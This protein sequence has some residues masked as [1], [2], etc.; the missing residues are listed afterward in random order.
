MSDDVIKATGKVADLTKVAENNYAGVSLWADAAQTKYRSLKDYLG[1]IAKIFDKIDAGSQTKLLE[2]LFG[3]RGAS[4]GSSIL[5]NFDQI[6]KAIEEMENAAGAADAEMEIIRSSWEYKLNNFKQT[7]VGIFQEL[8]DRGA[9]GDLIDALTKISELLSKIVGNK[10][11]LGSLAS[12]ITGIVASV[13]GL[14]TVTFLKDLKQII[15]GN[16]LNNTGNFLSGLFGSKQFS[17][18]DTSKMISTYSGLLSGDSEQINIATQALTELSDAERSVM[19]AAQKGKMSIEEFSN[20]LSTM[21]KGANIAKAAFNALATAGITLVAIAIVDW[22]TKGANALANLSKNTSEAAKAIRDSFQSAKDTADANLKTFDELAPRLEKLRKGVDD[23][24]NNLSLTDEEYAEFQSI[25]QTIADM[26]PDLIQGYND[27]NG[28]IV[29]LKDSVTELRKEYEKAQAAAYSLMITG[30]DE[31]GKSK[32]NTLIQDYKNT[33]ENPDW[34]GLIGL[35]GGGSYYR[36]LSPDD[37]YELLKNLRDDYNGTIENYQYIIAKFQWENPEYTAEDIT[38]FLAQNFED[39]KDLESVQKTAN[40][41]VKAYETTKKENLKNF[42][43]TVLTAILKQEGSDFYNLSEEA[44]SAISYVINN[45]DEELAYDL[46]KR[47]SGAIYTWVQDQINAI[48]GLSDS[49]LDRYSSINVE[50]P[51]EDILDLINEI[52]ALPGFDS[53][54]PLIIHL[55]EIIDNKQDLQDRVTNKLLGVNN[56]YDRKREDIYRS[57]DYQE[58]LTGLDKKQI[59]LVLNAAFGPKSFSKE[60]LDKYLEEL[61][62]VANEKTIEIRTVIDAVDTF[63]QTK[64]ALSS[65][66]DLYEE[67]VTNGKFASPDTLN[68]VEAAFGGIA[69]ESPIVAQALTNFENVMLEF[70]G[71]ANKA[72]E[73]IN[74]LV[75]AYIDQSDILKDL[76]EENKEWKIATLE[77]MGITN[78]QEVVESRLT[79]TSKASVQ[80]LSKLRDELVKFNEVKKNE[81]NNPLYDEK[82]FKLNSEE[83]IQALSDLKE[84][85]KE[86]LTVYDSEGEEYYRQLE[87]SDSFVKKHLADIQAM[88]E[89]DK[90]ALERVKQA[91]SKEQLGDSILELHPELSTQ[92]VE[93]QVNT[94]ADYFQNIPDME[95]GTSLDTGAFIDGLNTLLASGKYTAEQVAE[96]MKSMGY[97]VQINQAKGKVIVPNANGSHVSSTYGPNGPQLQRWDMQEMEMSFPS[98][99]IITK[100]G[101][102]G[103]GVQAEA[104]NYKPPKEESSSG[105]GG[106]KDET[107]KLTEQMDVL[108]WLYDNDVIDYKHYLD[109]KKVL[110]DRALAQG[111]I[112]EKRYFEE[113]HTWLRETLD[114]YNS[115]ISYATKL[116]DKEI[117]RLEKE[118]DER[119]KQIEN[120][121]KAAIE[122]VDS[123]LDALDKRIKKKNEE[124]EL[125]EKEH[126]QRKANMDMARAEYNLMRS[127]YQKSN[128]VK[129]CQAL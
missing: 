93:E 41:L 52:L 77:A 101:A 38:Q 33:F 71:D 108:K 3:K 17:Q 68:S 110:L 127:L 103:G 34:G 29:D 26:S 98:V 57:N 113:I 66:S 20:S 63:D 8:A 32:I 7:W 83:Y 79:A 102:Y 86:A 88:A 100:K 28:A 56:G 37:A 107:D 118:R 49:I 21:N 123:E 45:I 73:A 55:Q 104:A 13:K 11:A 27:Q 51:L 14:D 15:S 65:L 48:E 87:L 109:Q 78:A 82:G 75:S 16:N 6:E 19:S 85:V 80:A 111:L 91:A 125:M 39:L 99:K 95:I 4:V 129:L 120:E 23:L 43:D 116:L 24:G 122:A 70:P 44:Q 46:A 40:T 96:F 62:K 54:N 36:N 84:K 74:R 81:D 50:T 114:L 42:K 64:Q 124:I 72:Q 59:D 92:E 67:T 128:L 30:R 60:D 1:D 22:A 106:S 89:G 126:D 53:D 2:S 69:E 94:L 112:D 31:K 9:I 105:G 10:F 5:K 97:D 25:S 61:Q 12:V 119:L 47:G 18:F 76:T 90:E 35:I 117:D 115:V 58:W 121:K